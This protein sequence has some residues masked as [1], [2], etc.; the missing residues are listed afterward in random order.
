MLIQ[1]RPPFGGLFVFITKKA[2]RLLYGF[3]KKILR[4]CK[5]INIVVI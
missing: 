1:N 3:H 5:H 4:Y 2:L